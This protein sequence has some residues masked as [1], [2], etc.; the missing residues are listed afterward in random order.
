MMG[1]VPHLPID[2]M[3]KRGIDKEIPDASARKKVLHS[4][5]KTFGAS[6]KQAGVHAE[7]RGDIFG[8]AGGTVTEEIY[9]DPIALSAMLEHLQKL[10]T[11]TAH[12]ESRPIRLLP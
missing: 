10:P 6:L 4:F 5:R 8:H 1:R 3:T 12:L 9:V 7:I 2:R 11:V